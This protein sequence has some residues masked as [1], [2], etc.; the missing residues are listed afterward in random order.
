MQRGL[1]KLRAKQIFFRIKKYNITYLFS[2]SDAIDMPVKVHGKSYLL[3]DTA[4]IRRKSKISLT[5]EKYSVVQAL[6][7]INRCDIALVLIDAEDGLTDQDTK[8]IGL[9]YERGKTCII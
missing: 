7:S 9:A 8:I 4:G 3:I 1:L 5:L 6:K 2:L